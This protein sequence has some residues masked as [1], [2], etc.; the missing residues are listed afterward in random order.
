MAKD[1]TWHWRWL[2]ALSVGSLALAFALPHLGPAPDLQEKR[3]L[4]DLPAWPRRLSDL[5]AFRHGM[6]RYVE[7]RF[8]ARPYL[9]GGLNR[10]RLALGVS[11]SERVIVGR[12]GWLFYDNGDHFATARNGQPLSEAETAAWLTGLAGRTE[13]LAA[14]G[15]HYLVVSAPLKETVYPQFAPTWFAGPDPHRDS[16]MLSQRAAMT[17]AGTM[18]NLYDAE[19]TP[20]RWG[21]KTYSRHD[22]H[23]TGLGA[24]EGYR[25]ILE[26]LNAM[27]VT[28]PPRPLTDFTETPRDGFKPRDLALM[29]GVANSV[30]VDVP[31]FTAP[32]IEDRL[33]IRYL[34]PHQDWTAPRIVDTGETGK[35]VLLMTFDS[36]STA[37]LPFLYGHFSRL[38]LAHDQDGFWRQ[39]L[40]DRFHPDVVI[41]EVVESGLRFAMRDSPA[42]SDQAHARIVGLPPVAPILKATPGNDTLIGGPG[43]E[44]IRGGRGDD[45]IHGGPGNDWLSGDRGNDTLWGGPGADTFHSFA[46]AGIDRVMDF[47]VAEGDHVLLDPGTNYK[48]RQQGP[49][50][51]I[52]MGGG[53]RVILVGVKAWSLRPDSITVGH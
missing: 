32:R 37:L 15:A 14:H 7:D 8:P 25:A 6:D 52:D 3:P 4:A 5:A 26:R 48:V 44:T 42:T 51:I 40:I 53:N 17:G 33:Q 43:D 18:L 47:S 49:D 1:L 29:L 34:T 22:T 39:D 41:T 35:P 21:L 24:Y 20:T 23:W 27:G 30:D 45:E 50:T 19:V 31:Q 11:G 2:S 12:D 46:Q 9:I 38:I 36:Y 13:T 10:L 16:A 28:D